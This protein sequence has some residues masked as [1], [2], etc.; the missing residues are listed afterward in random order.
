ME[1][2]T[3]NQSKLFTAWS[4]FQLKALVKI[5]M[6]FPSF[7]GMLYCIH[8][9]P[10]FR[11]P[12][13]F[14]HRRTKV[15]QVTFTSCHQTSSSSSSSSMISSSMLSS[16]LSGEVADTQPG[17]ISPW[18]GWNLQ[19]KHHHHHRRHHHHNHI[20]TLCIHECVYIYVCI[21]I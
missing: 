2:I 15:I 17:G 12:K 10:N 16:C 13:V 20:Q 6:C 5:S 1:G 19:K 18:K 7:L 8:D 3:D 21:Y 14:H 9:M 4:R 11:G